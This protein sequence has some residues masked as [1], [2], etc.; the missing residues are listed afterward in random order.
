MVPPKPSP[1]PPRPYLQ[2]EGGN[3]AVELGALVVQGAAGHG[4]LALLAGAERTE[5]LHGLGDG[6]AV[7]SHDDAPRGLAADVD[8]EEDL[9]KW[10]KLVF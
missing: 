2:H 8:I 3:H 6:V 4:R 1:M 5:I 10:L 9:V 7:Q